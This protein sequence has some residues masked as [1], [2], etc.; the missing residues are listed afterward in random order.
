MIGELGGLGLVVASVV[1][2]AAQPALGGFAIYRASHN[3]YQDCYLPTG[4]LSGT[5][6]D[7]LDTACDLSLGDPVSWTG[8]PRHLKGHACQSIEVGRV[9]RV[10]LTEYATRPRHRFETRVACLRHAITPTKGLVTP[11]LIPDFDAILRAS[12]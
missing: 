6:K 8:N 2:R 9:S 3:D 1:V 4:I 12:A 10:N 7:A 11:S 5:V